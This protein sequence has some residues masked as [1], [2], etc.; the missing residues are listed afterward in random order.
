MSAITPECSG[1]TP[2]ASLARCSMHVAIPSTL[3]AFSSVLAGCGPAAR[4]VLKKALASSSRR[5]R[6]AALMRWLGILVLAM[7]LPRLAS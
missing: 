1:L 4:Y 3:A 2:K 5:S 7:R 6:S